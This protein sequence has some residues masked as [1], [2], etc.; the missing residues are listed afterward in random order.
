MTQITEL[1]LDEDD[2]LS[3]VDAISLVEYPAIEENFVFLSDQKNKYVFAKADE[4]KRLL[5]GPALIPNKQIYRLDQTTGEEYYAHF[6]KETIR[7]VSEL[8]L[9]KNNHHNY[10]YEHESKVGGVSLFESWIVDFPDMDKSKAYGFEP[11]EGWWM[12]SLKVHSDDLWSKIKSGEVKGFS[13]EGYFADKIKA[14]RSFDVKAELD[15]L[16]A[17]LDK[18]KK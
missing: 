14:S 3:G 4:E 1:I 12:V 10:T 18:A 7:K 13:I 17:D 11:K 15:R 5:V 16:I 8:Y 6:S 2:D 9:Q